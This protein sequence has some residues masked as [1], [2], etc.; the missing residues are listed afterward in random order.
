M[1]FLQQKIFKLS[2]ENIFHSNLLLVNKRQK[3]L[4]RVQ[5][6]TPKIKMLHIK[7]KASQTTFSKEIAFLNETYI[8]FQ[9]Y[10]SSKV[11]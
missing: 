2:F 7:K 4:C 11:L 1:Y 9:I 10:I 6:K 3:Q 8:T 5:N